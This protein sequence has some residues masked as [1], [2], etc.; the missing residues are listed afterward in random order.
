MPKQKSRAKRFIPLVTLA[1][2]KEQAAAIA[3]GT[4]SQQVQQSRKQ[5]DQLKQYRHEYTQQLMN[6]ANQG[7]GA[8]L[9]KTYKNFIEGLDQAIK[10]QHV[11]VFES[12]KQYAQQK[13]RWMHQHQKKR[14]ME[15]TVEK[16]AADE[17]RDKN[18]KEQNELDEHSNLVTPRTLPH[19]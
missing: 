1:K 2:N 12:Q 4:C 10:N 15:V 3:L 14:V 6:D 5:L 18:R 9:L 8:G 17:N 11:Q 13:Q 19:K 16:F 7:M